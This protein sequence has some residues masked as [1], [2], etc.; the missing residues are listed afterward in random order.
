MYIGILVKYPLLLSNLMKL[1]FSRQIFEK[2]SDIKFHEIPCSGSRVVPRGQTMTKLI[3][4]F[5]NVVKPPKKHV[6]GGFSILF[7]S[8][9]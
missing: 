8:A 9:D 5:R 4:T 2:F 6:V 1:D 7:V 3:V